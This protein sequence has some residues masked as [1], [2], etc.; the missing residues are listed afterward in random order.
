MTEKAA[1]NIRVN[2]ETKQN[3]EKVLNKLGMPMS[4]AIDIYLRQ[5]ALTDSI[6]FDL[7]SKPR[8]NKNDHDTA[9]MIAEATAQYDVVKSSWE[10]KLS[11]VT[12]D[13]MNMNK[14]TKEELEARLAKHAQDA[15]NG[16]NVE[17]NKAFA[18]LNKELGI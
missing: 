14:M 9:M 16:K 4:V 13:W 18:Q 5:I 1:I 7:S 6:P 3:A 11:D 12:P 2:K 8:K 17:I 15:K 10:D